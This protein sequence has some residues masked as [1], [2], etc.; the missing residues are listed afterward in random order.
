M[1]NL[2]IRAFDYAPS[3][4]MVQD[5]QSRSALERAFTFDLN[6]RGRMAAVRESGAVVANYT[7]DIY[8]QRVVKAITGETPVHYIYDTDGRLIAEADG[9]SGEVLREYIWFGLTP[10]ATLSMGEG[11]VSVEDCNP[12]LIAD[13][14]SRLSARQARIELITERL[15]SIGTTVAERQ[16]R[17]AELD[18]R[19]AA[20]QARLDTINP[21]R[22]IRVDVLTA[23]LAQIDE[24]LAD[25]EAS[26]TRLTG[27][28]ADLEARLIELEDI[29]LRLTARIERLEARC[30]A[31]GG[32]GAS[33]GAANDNEMVLNYL[34][35]D[36]LGRPAFATDTAGEIVWGEFRIVPANQFW[37]NGITTPF[38][39]QIET[40]GALT[41]NLHPPPSNRWRSAPIPGQYEDEETGF[42]SHC[43]GLLD[44][45]FIRR[46]KYFGTA[47]PIAKWHRTYDPTL[48]RYLQSDPIGLSGGLNRYAYVGGNPVNTTDFTG[49]NPGIDRR[50]DG[51]AAAARDFANR[52]PA[53]SDA[54]R[55][56]LNWLTGTGPDDIV[57]GPSSPHIPNLPSVMKAI[58][59][60]NNKNSGNFDCGCPQLLDVKGYKSKF[61][62]KGYF[63]A[64]V[65]KNPTWHFIGS[66]AINVY[67]VDCFNV[68]VEV[69]NNS[70]FQ[71]FAY[72]IA[73]HWERS[74]FGPMGN[75]RQT[76]WWE[77]SR[78]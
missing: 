63:D 42:Y 51:A 11:G 44:L 46:V 12:A 76:Y 7:Y 66:F 54:M 65:T 40:M 71:S 41:Q 32:Q 19:R 62:A 52:N 8:Q 35:A 49:L 58:D 69:T 75:M 26:L 70:S 38:G 78:F 30:A 25:V 5:T 27:R 10:I 64:T 13:L 1:T 74:T 28:Q 56:T 24:R 31:N 60:Y 3:G 67:P 37:S 16:A 22:V 23:R 45:Y 33:A 29:T 57:H 77:Q 47:K 50:A 6:A 21:A 20:V 68:R 73:P 15:V 17:Q 39:V 34:H 48:G 43:R 18:E 53:L 72:G 36:H 59:F 9:A 55:M 61:G 2:P 14:Q 4:Q